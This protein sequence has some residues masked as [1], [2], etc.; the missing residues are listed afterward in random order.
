MK[1]YIFVIIV[2]ILIFSIYIG[3]IYYY[4]KESITVEVTYEQKIAKIK[5]DQAILDSQFKNQLESRN[6]QLLKNEIMKEMGDKDRDGLTYSEELKLGTSDNEVDSDADGIPDALDKHPSGGGEIYRISVNWQHNSLPYT[7]QFGIPEDKYLYYKNQLRNDY[8]Y[9]DGR[10]ATPNDP[11]IQTI[12]KDIMDV[13]ISTGETCKT[14]IAIDFVESMIYQY[15]IDF[16]KNT[17]YPKYAIETIIDKRG[18]CEDTSFLMASILRAL[19]IDTVL[20]LYSDH[21]AVGVWCDNC[22]GTYY[23]INGR[24][25]FFLE[26]TGEPGSWELGNI[27]GKYVNEN[28]KIIEIN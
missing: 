6:T 21:M 14:C 9:Q 28:P 25:Y 3:Y 19:N 8:N 23:P 7:T 2:F 1:K 10:F 13:S 5:S 24:K 18:D 11:I 16:N 26:T 17:D 22:S 20:L 4:N 27:W 12:A 15:D